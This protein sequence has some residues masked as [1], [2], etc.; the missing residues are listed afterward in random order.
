MLCIYGSLDTVYLQI[1]FVYTREWQCILRILHICIS[2]IHGRVCARRR[3]FIKMMKTEISCF[4]V[5]GFVKF[6]RS[7]IRF[8]IFI[9]HISHQLKEAE[10]KFHV[11]VL[12]LSIRCN[13]VKQCANPESC[14]LFNSELRVCCN[15]YV[16]KHLLLFH[17][18]LSFCKDK[19]TIHFAF[20]MNACRH[21][22]TLKLFSLRVK[23]V[24]FIWS[25]CHTLVNIFEFAGF[26]WAREMQC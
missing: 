20:K 8:S 12:C 15:C 14:E 16:C 10:Y 2:I 19:R 26:V 13:D 11:C 24:A 17:L 18:R 25:W 23:C 1:C 5:V 7:W 6:K 4:R 22:N 9:S 21:E 3:G